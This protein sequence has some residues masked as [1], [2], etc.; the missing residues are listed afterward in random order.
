MQWR[1]DQGRLDY[2]RFDMIKRIASTLCS[3]ENVKLRVR[4]DP[5]R[6]NLVSST[7]LSF[8][9]GYYKVWRNYKRVFGCC[10]LAADID[11]QM[12]CTEI[13]HRIAAPSPDDMPAD[14]YFGNFIKRFYF[15]SPIFEGYANRGA[16]H[17]PVCAIL[18]LLLARLRTGQ[19]PVVTIDEIVSFLVA[20]NCTGEESVEF[21]AG[22]TRGHIHPRKMKLG[23]FEN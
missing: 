23:K 20:N 4:I 14:V 12:I 8:A 19:Q 22:L 9:P 3:L 7:N 5:L 1:W 21:Y 15:P 2:F 11:G 17:F 6:S 16:Q 18:K 13:C 10:L